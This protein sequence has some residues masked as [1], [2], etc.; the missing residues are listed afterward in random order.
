[1]RDCDDN[2][3]IVCSIENIDPMG[4]HTGDAI[5]RRAGDDASDREYQTM[6]DAA[7]A[8]I[9]KVA[10]M[11]AAAISSSRESARRRYARNRDEPA[12]LALFRAGVEGPAFRSR[13]SD[14]AGGRTDRRDRQRHYEDDPAR[15]SRA[16]LRRGEMP[17]LRLREVRDCES[18][19][20]TQM[21]SLASRWPSSHFKEAFQKAMRALEIGTVRMD[22]RAIRRR[23]VT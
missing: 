1:M 12:C 11:R 8:V 6:R 18:A 7:V 15:S 20:T 2:V 14:E 5:H 17:A 21:K 22:G 16:R 10:S 13:A 23:S 4:V 19:L 3:V 9:R